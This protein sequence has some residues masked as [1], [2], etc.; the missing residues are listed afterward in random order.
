MTHVFRCKPS[1]NDELK[2]VVNDFATSMDAKMIKKVCASARKRF[3][4]MCET[5]GRHFEHLI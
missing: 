3:V 2:Q 5:L 4:K 1:T